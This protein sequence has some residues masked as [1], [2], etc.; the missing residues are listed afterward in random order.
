MGMAASA[1][2]LGGP[3]VAYSPTSKA[4]TGT[5]PDVFT[6]DLSITAPKSG[7]T[8]PIT[9]QLQ[10]TATLFPLG[11]AATAEG[12]ISF[13]NPTLTFNSA[14]ETQKTVVTIRFPGSALSSDVPNGVYTYAIKTAGWPAGVG[15]SGASIDASVV[16]PAPPTLSK[17]TTV[18]DSPNQSATFT[19]SKLPASID[20]TFHATTDDVS[21][22]ITKIEA[23]FGDGETMLPVSTR[24]TGLQGSSVTG[25]GSFTV[26]AAG[27]YVLQVSATNSEGSGDARAS[28]TFTVV[29]PSKPSVNGVAFFDLNE[30][31]RMDGSDFG[32]GGITVRLLNR[33]GRIVDTEVTDA[34]GSCTFAD[35]STGH[36]TVLAD[37]ACGFLPTTPI[38]RCVTVDSGD[39]VVESFGYNLNF[40]ALILMRADGNSHGFW[41]TNIGKAIDGKTKGVQISAEALERYTTAL[42]EFASSSFDGLTMERALTTLSSNSSKP[43]NLLA[44]QLLAAEYNYQNKAY[45]NGNTTLTYA[46]LAWGEHVLENTDDYSSCYVLWAKDWF[47]AYNNTHGGCVGIPGF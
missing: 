22:V 17:P 12:Y 16:L 2:A 31:G 10:K 36:Y 35:V 40:L 38:V 37:C 6:Y 27:T 1:W 46:F 25:S 33:R 34:T 44:K 7:V 19:L 32:L 18:I 5:V 28:Y 45:L 9:V 4:I 14:G 24:Q 8:F 20:F 41:K 43:A 47:D 21:P 23:L 26:K 42:G 11:N 30:N 13:D 15:N 29:A 3:V 39:A